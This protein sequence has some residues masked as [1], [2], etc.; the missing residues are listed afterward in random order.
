MTGLEARPD[1][2]KFRSGRRDEN[3]SASPGPRRPATRNSA[4]SG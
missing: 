3:G 2:V 4:R 1:E